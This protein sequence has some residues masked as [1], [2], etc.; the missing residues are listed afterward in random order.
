[1]EWIIWIYFNLKLI[2]FWM[3]CLKSI[4]EGNSRYSV[5][6]EYISVLMSILI[7]KKMWWR[8]SGILQIIIFV[9]LK[10]S[11]SRLVYGGH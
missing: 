8:N 10:V 3:R 5:E 9:I 11:E 7:R 1:M 6:K 2:R 4:W